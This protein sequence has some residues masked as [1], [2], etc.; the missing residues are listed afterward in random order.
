[1]SDIKGQGHCEWKWRNRFC[2][3]FCEKWIDLH[4]TDTKM[5]INPFNTSLNTF[6]QQK[7]IIFAI[8]IWFL[9]II[10]ATTSKMASVFNQT[11]HTYNSS[12]RIL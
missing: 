2:T 3:H 6:H 10:F 9:K 11:W 12:P 4:Q 1:V 5:I 8:F 7:H